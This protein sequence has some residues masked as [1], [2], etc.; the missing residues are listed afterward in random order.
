M[1][2]AAIDTPTTA[3]EK[4]SFDRNPRKV[5]A[6]DSRMRSGCE[7]RYSGSPAGSTSVTVS[8]V[9]IANSKTNVSFI[10]MKFA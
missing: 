9:P 5:N 10:A 6:R 7:A 1:C 8:A 3:A 4:N 2:A